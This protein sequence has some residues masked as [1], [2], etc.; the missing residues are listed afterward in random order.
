MWRAVIKRAPQSGAHRGLVSKRTP[1]RR[2]ACARVKGCRYRPRTITVLHGKGNRRRVTG[3]DEAAG[4]LLNLFL[5]LARQA[6]IAKRVHP[7]GLRHTHAAELAAEG[8][9]VNLIQQQL[10]HSSLATTD[11]RWAGRSRF[12]LRR[13]TSRPFDARVNGSYKKWHK[14]RHPLGR[15][16]KEKGPVSRALRVAGAR[17]ERLPA[18]AFRIEEVRP[19]EPVPH[20][21]A[22]R[23][24]RR[25]SVALRVRDGKVVEHAPI[26][27]QIPGDRRVVRPGAAE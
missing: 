14:N 4:E 6:G 10:A 13:E 23:C 18:T 17:Y 9:P 16:L 22:A 11:R 12:A 2:G 25:S 8:V 27:I 1:S 7:H 21:R 19:L 3:I 24:A 15:R 20:D 5:R 26:G